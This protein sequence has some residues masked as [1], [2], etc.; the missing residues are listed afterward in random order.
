[1]PAYHKR[2]ENT[3]APTDPL[4]TFSGFPRS[5]STQVPDV[6]F[7]EIMPFLNLAETRVLLYIIRRTIGFKKDWDGISLDQMANGIIKTNGERL[8]HGTGL[9]ANSIRSATKSLV[10]KGVLVVSEQF[11]RDGGQKE[12]RYCLRWEN[13]TP[14]Q[15]LVPPPSQ[16]VDPTIYRSTRD[17]RTRDSSL[18]SVKQKD[19][20]SSSRSPAQRQTPDIFIPMIA[21][22]SG[23]DFPLTAEWIKSRWPDIDND[24]LR[25]ILTIGHNEYKQIT[26]NILKDIEFLAV[27]KKATKKKQESPALYLHTVPQILR[28]WA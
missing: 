13:P 15:S 20:A 2:G 5:N 28:S 3:A 18:G 10:E 4:S 7:D 26:G 19:L 17:S 8:D 21:D 1:M 9:H 27:V 23:E 22:P 25:R 6:F 24:F 16:Q 11:D 12:N 14:S